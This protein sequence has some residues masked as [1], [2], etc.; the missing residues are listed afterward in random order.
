MSEGQ[1]TDANGNLI[2]WING[3]A[4][5][6][7]QG[8]L[9]IAKPALPMGTGLLQ[10]NSGLETGFMGSGV[11]TTSQGY[12]RQNMPAISTGA[13]ND[14]NSLSNSGQVLT[15][16]S[17]LGKGLG[18][19]PD[20]VST[21][22]QASYG[23]PAQQSYPTYTAPAWDES[24]VNKYAAKFSAP[25]I[26]EVRR[27]IRDAIL[28]SGASSSPVLRR[29][30]LGNA[31]DKAG[32]GLGKIMGQATQYGLG[33]YNTEYGRNVD[34]AKTNFTSKISNINQQNSL[35]AQQSMALFQ[36]AL[37]SYMSG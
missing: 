14:R 34:E 12:Q 37:N 7:I 24:K 8:A 1:Y 3:P 18:A 13:Y 17:P 29:Y 4:P 9:P 33:A 32:E 35:A 6:N 5:N 10:S 26:G 2:N 36:A 20:V 27:A 25:Y 21:F 30:Q 15:I 28:R 16:G 23:I 11:D 22:N 19:L 31:V